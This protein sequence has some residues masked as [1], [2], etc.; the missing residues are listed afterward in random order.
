[1]ATSSNHNPNHISS[2]VNSDYL[3]QHF[4]NNTNMVPTLYVLH[5]AAITKPHAIEHLAADLTGYKID[6]AVVTETHLK[7]EHPDNSLRIDGY[8]LYRRD[9]VIRRRGGV[10]VYVHNR[11]AADV[12]TCT[13]DSPQLEILWL[14]VRDD[15]FSVFICAV[16]HPPK[17]LH[18]PSAVLDYIEACVDEL[19]TKFPAATVVLAG[20][21]NAL[22]DAKVTLKTTLHSIVNRPMRIKYTSVV[23]VM[24]QSKLSCQ[25][26]AAIIKQ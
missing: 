3:L 9:R 17:P 26:F 16:Y 22:A 1:V 24:Q 12:W 25:M 2:S 23:P 19:T 18:Q 14:S 7:T 4:S 20:D 15:H 13:G 8:K 11:L 10:A 6:V 21:F 5:G